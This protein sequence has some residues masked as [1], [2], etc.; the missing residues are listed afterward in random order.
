MVD[1]AVGSVVGDADRD[2]GLVDATSTTPTPTRSI[3]FSR[4]VSPD[5]IYVRGHQVRRIAEDIFA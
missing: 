3:S 1:D 5:Y 2:S 4:S